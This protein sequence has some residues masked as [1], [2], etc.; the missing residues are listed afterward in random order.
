M[1]TDE[2]G[3]INILLIGYGGENHAGGYLADSLMLASRNPQKKA[4]TMLSIPRDL[5]IQNT[6]ERVFGR[7]NELFSRAVGRNHEFET[8]AREMSKQVEQITSI[9]PDYYA[10]VD[11]QGFEKVIDTL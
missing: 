11:F 4:V 5:Y 1:K 2:Y 8:G 7:I 6:G 10:T 9:K 3:N